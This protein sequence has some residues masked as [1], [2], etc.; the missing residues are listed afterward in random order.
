MCVSQVPLLLIHFNATNHIATTI[1][2]NNTDLY[3][4]LD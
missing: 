1:A 3:V 2:G 4:R